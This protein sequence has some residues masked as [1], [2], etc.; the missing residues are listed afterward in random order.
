MIYQLYLSEFLTILQIQNYYPIVYMDIAHCIQLPYI[1]TMLIC[2]YA[3]HD[4]NNTPFAFFIYLSKAF[5]TID[6]NILNQK[7]Y[8]RIRN[9][10]C[11]KYRH[12]IIISLVRI[13]SKPLLY[14]WHKVII[15]VTL[16]IFWRSNLENGI[17]IFK[18]SLNTHETKM[19]IVRKIN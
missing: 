15:M 19:M 10:V 17:T 16:K 6:H 8:L 5:D 3:S 13:P 18:F 1:F 12:L 14:E 11:L 2:R 4:S 9:I 7:F